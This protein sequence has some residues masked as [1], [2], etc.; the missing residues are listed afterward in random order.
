MIRLHSDPS[1]P[2][3]IAGLGVEESE[4]LLYSYEFSIALGHRLRLRGW[5]CV[6]LE[7]SGDPSPESHWNLRYPDYN[8]FTPDFP[9]LELTRL[10]GL[11]ADHNSN[12]S[13]LAAP[14]ITDEIF[15][16]ATLL[17]SLRDQAI[18][19]VHGVVADQP[20][21]PARFDRPGLN[22]QE[23]EGLTEDIAKSWADFV[24]IAQNMA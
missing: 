17:Y 4:P 24:V 22:E 10:L 9:E 7:P 2:V 20:W 13:P 5:Y 16:L 23:L 8:E 6:D 15:V 3:W 14:L 21:G 12:L 1:L 18:Q 11:E 19:A